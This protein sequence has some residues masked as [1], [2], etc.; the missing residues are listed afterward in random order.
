ML[1][2]HHC[3]LPGFEPVRNI[4]TPPQCTKLDFADACVFY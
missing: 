2:V 1:V 3:I 4:I